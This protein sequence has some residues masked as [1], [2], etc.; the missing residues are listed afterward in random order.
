MN[1]SPR[2]TI[3]SRLHLY[4]LFCILLLLI[5]GCAAQTDADISVY[6]GSDYLLKL[7]IT[8]PRMAVEMVGERAI[9]QQLDQLVAD[10]GNQAG[11]TAKWKR[12][13]FDNEQAVYAVEISGNCREERCAGAGF[14]IQPQP[15]GGQSA[16]MFTGDASNL[17]QLGDRVTLTLHADRVVSTNGN[18]T[19]PG[20]VVWQ[21]YGEDPYAVVLPIQRMNW[22]LI[23]A[24][25]VAVALGIAGMVLL[26]QSR[27]RNRPSEGPHCNAC[28]AQI[29]SQARYCPKCGAAVAENPTI[30]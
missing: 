16:V 6:E 15:A 18:E 12:T 1:T 4:F 11:T 23:G 28:G 3:S 21:M 9:T 24:L 30:Q 22:L 13:A 10:A 25:V 17:A 8:L 20:T 29:P 7:T 14:N 26:E 19:E 2:S 27:R 5:A